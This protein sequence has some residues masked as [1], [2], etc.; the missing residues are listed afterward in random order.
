MTSP[1]CSRPHWFNEVQADVATDGIPTEEENVPGILLG[2]KINGD[3]DEYCNCFEKRMRAPT[4]PSNFELLTTV[5]MNGQSFILSY[6]IL[7][8]D[9]YLFFPQE[10]F[11]S[12][13]VKSLVL[14]IG[15]QNDRITSYHSRKSITSA[16][17]FDL[18]S[19]SITMLDEDVVEVDITWFDLYPDDD[20]EALRPGYS[21]EDPVI[22][23]DSDD[24]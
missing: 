2:K 19:P 21:I 1:T 13:E 8:Y 11:N 22:I 9:N 10:K 14:V 15:G 6:R 7:C 12:E 18:L 24:E 16:H 4:H 3:I 5:S 20:E 17:T 23:I